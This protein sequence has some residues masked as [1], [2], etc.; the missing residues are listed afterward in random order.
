[1]VGMTRNEALIQAITFDLVHYHRARM[2]QRAGLQMQLLR[3][4]KNRIPHNIARLNAIRVA[5]VDTTRNRLNSKVTIDE[6][7]EPLRH[8]VSIE[9]IHYADQVMAD[10]ENQR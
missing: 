4:E 7:L 10:P 9:A 1:M 6:V 5:M 2:A 3:A 8:G